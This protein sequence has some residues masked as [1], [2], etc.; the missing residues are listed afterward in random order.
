MPITDLSGTSHFF[1]TAVKKEQLKSSG[2]YHYLKSTKNPIS[3][4]I[5]RVV[6]L[7][8]E[9]CSISIKNGFSIVV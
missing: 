2:F 7:E 9:L 5:R 6:S 1:G 8:N 4:L 3:F